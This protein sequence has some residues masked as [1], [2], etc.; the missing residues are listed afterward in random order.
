[1]EYNNSDINQNFRT[2]N[3]SETEIDILFVIIASCINFLSV[4][5]IMVTQW[6]QYYFNNKIGKV[7]MIKREGGYFEFS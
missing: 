3:G 7:N 6:F 1:M 4:T 2:I 5:I